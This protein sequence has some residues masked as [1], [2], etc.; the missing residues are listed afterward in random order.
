MGFVDRSW[1]L[2]FRTHLDPWSFEKSWRMHVADKVLQTSTETHNNIWHLHYLVWQNNDDVL[3]LAS[4]TRMMCIDLAEFP[5]L[6]YLKVALDAVKPCHWTC[7]WILEN[8]A[9]VQNVQRAIVEDVRPEYILY[10]IT[11]WQGISRHLSTQVLCRIR[12]CTPL[13][14]LWGRS[15]GCT[16]CNGGTRSRCFQACESRL[17]KE[18]PGSNQRISDLFRYDIDP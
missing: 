13:R 4:D 1:A 6:E 5:A 17:I 7:R 3:G 18:W 14:I 9:L 10:L 8:F 16:T 2:S 11:R 12:L 15:N